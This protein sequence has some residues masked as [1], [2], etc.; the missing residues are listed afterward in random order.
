MAQIIRSVNEVINNALF[1]IGELATNETPDAFML[2][3]GLEIINSIL[4]K[5]NA[6]SIYIPYLTTINFN[7]VPEQG[8]YIISNM[9]VVTDVQENRIV[10][11]SF[12]N[13][14]LTDPVNQTIVYPLKII[15]K[16][17]FEYVTRVTQVYTRPWLIFLNKQ[18]LESIVTVYPTPD[19]AY[20]CTLKC[21]VMLN[22]VEAQDDLIQLP[23][24][25]Y[26]FLKYAVAREFITYYPSGNWPQTS[27]D[28]Y[29]DMYAILKNT[30]ETDL[31]INP[32]GILNSNQTYYWQ[33]ILSS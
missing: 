6:D 1:L 31:T 25:Y 27:E 32:T 17:Q 22:S 13:Y 15:N 33:S 21:K 30:N 26:K 11:L 20:P 5:C 12:A 8:D 14:S 2:A 16:A 9:V 4:D 10:D 3:S 18:P 19:Q 24:F 29:Q 28:E 23:P 7:M